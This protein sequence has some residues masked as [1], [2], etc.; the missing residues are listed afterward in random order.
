M[1]DEVGRQK[2]TSGSRKSALTF[3]GH[4]PTIC[5]LPSAPRSSF[6]LHPSSFSSAVSIYFLEVE[7]SDATYFKAALTGH[8][9]HFVSKLGKVGPRAEVLSVFIHSPVDRAFLE[10]HPS[11]RLIAA[12]STAAENIDLDACRER[13]VAVANVPSYGEHTVAEHTFALILALSRRLREVTGESAAD[14]K[15]SYSN[16]RAFE[17]RGK[18]L[19]VVG[20]GR[21][22]RHVIAV[23]QAFG[24]R[25]LAFDIHAPAAVAQ[26]AG[27]DFAPLE[28]LLAEAH[29]L[30]LHV[31]VGPDTRHLLNRETL[32]RCRAGVLVI[33][34]ARGALIDTDALIDAL[35][36]G[37]VGGA[38]LDVLEEE[39]TVREE[40][41]RVISD[42][43]IDRLHAVTTPGELHDREAGRVRELQGLLRNKRLIARP[44]VLFTPHVAFN[45]IEAVERINSATAQNI[46]RFLEGRPTN[47]VT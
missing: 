11:L 39:N 3:F 27:F 8:E 23:A 41:T 47:L 46:L 22:G 10:A 38:G 4:L 15:L 30:T 5:L 1:K 40:M 31:P 33:N 28:R 20:A 34:T 19:G 29:V 7:P 14:G 16:T 37:Q 44:N 13:G 6:I 9:V 24:M 18:T 35:D 17:L 45:S 36:S 2:P 12:R 32:A 42:Q 25:V 21:I 26:H 43:I